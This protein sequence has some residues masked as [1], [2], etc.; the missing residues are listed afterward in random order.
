VET[1]SDISTI[2]ISWL[3]RLINTDVSIDSKNDIGA[4]NVAFTKTSCNLIDDFV[5]ITW[6]T[7]AICPQY[8]FQLKIA[9]AA[10]APMNRLIDG[11]EGPVVNLSHISVDGQ[12]A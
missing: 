12:H 2:D 1:G 11:G 9:T 7:W 8:E 3:K 6:I 10:K 5:P 4:L